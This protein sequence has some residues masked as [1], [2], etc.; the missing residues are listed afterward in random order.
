MTW[1]LP[2]ATFRA[3]TRSKA[4]RLITQHQIHEPITRRMLSADARTTWSARRAA[5]MLPIIFGA[6]GVYERQGG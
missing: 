4:R 2:T 3:G 6:V 1:M 5:R